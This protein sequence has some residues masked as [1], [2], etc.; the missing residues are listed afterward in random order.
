MASKPNIFVAYPYS[1]S[2]RDYRAAFR[3]V[4]Q[5]YGVKFLYADERITNKQILDKIVGMIGESEFSIFD[6][7]TWN[8]N[9]ALELGV[10]IGSQQDYYIL[11]NPSNGQEHPPSDLGG[12]DR[13]QYA[14]YAELTEEVGRLMRQQ[15][16]AP[17][18]EQVEAGTERGAN[19]LGQLEEMKAE[20]PE[21]VGRSPGMQIGSIA[22]A[23]GMPVEFTQ[24]LVRP[25][26][27][28]E[29]RTEGAKR[30]TRYYRIDS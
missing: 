26:V 21:I 1:F 6:V 19:V 24:N 8:P 10:A 16:G 30:G 28:A 20:I 2:K 11:F 9:V 22:S 3:R 4:A 27:G 29:L 12:I 15:F 5:Q 17:R 23:I 7:T 18:E 14:D 25:L 13:L